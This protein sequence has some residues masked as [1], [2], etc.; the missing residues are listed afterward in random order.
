MISTEMALTRRRYPERRRSAAI[1]LSRGLASC[2]QATVDVTIPIV[3][4]VYHAN[5]NFTITSAERRLFGSGTVTNPISGNTTTIMVAAATPLVVKPA[6]GATNAVSNACGYSLADQMR[7]EVTGPT[8]TLKSTLNYSS[9]SPTA[10][11]NNRTFTDPSGQT[12]TLPDTT[13]DTPCDSGGTI[14]DWAHTY[15]QQWACL[16]RESGQATLTLS[17]AGT[18]S[19]TI[20]DE[21][22]P[23]SGN[24]STYPAT[25]IGANPRALRGF[26]IGGPASSPYR[27]D[28]NWTLDKSLKG[29]VQFSS[30]AYIPPGPVGTGGMCVAYAARR[31]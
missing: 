19:V 25:T 14:N 18:N 16:P 20:I 6:T 13:I 11:A 30:Y 3:G 28:F 7:F 29:F 27:E 24:L 12:T 26:F 5:V 4:H 17:V 23:A 8:G 1:R 21:D 10:T 15:D 9:N 31:P 2:G 22:P